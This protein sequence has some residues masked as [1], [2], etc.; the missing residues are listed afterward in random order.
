M[1]SAPGS[2]PDRVLQYFLWYAE[3]SWHYRLPAASIAC[4]KYIGKGLYVMDLQG[5]SLSKHFTSDTRNFIKSF[6][7]VAS[8]NYPESI[9]KSYIINAPF[10]FRTAWSVVG[11]F[12]DARQ[13][14]KFSILGGQK[15]Y[16]PKLLE[17]MDIEDIPVQFGGKD[18]SCTF[19]HE[20]GPW[21]SL[22]PS[23][24]GPREA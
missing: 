22:M 9:Y 16:L 5:F 8:D 10:A 24:A 14:S 21:Q 20:Q 1:L 15:E 3:A 11:A 6:I 17:V 19:Y 18:A 4:G 23:P 2:T 12:L 7:K 13:K